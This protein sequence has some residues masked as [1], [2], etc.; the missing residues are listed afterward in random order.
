MTATSGGA[1]AT[2]TN[3]TSG[4]SDSGE[5][6]S[7]M[8]AYPALGGQS[9]SSFGM[10]NAGFYANPASQSPY[11]VLPQS[12]PMADGKALHLFSLRM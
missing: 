11:G 5:D 10:S 6:T 4:G 7:T 9:A 2:T 1:T 3:S 12:Y 8:Q